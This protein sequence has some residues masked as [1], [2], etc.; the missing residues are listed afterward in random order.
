VV[1]HLAQPREPSPAAGF[2][3][4]MA[5]ATDQ[6]QLAG[7]GAAFGG[8]VSPGFNVEV[9]RCY[10]KSNG[11]TINC[12]TAFAGLGVELTSYTGTPGEVHA[13]GSFTID[14]TN[15]IPSCIWIRQSSIRT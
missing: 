2:T 7:W 12:V 14:A 6:S 3:A 4:I 8:S 13:Y 15:L 10:T 5:D 11:Q 1:H 9:N